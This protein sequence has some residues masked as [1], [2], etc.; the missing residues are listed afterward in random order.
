M[1]LCLTTNTA[2]SVFLLFTHHISVQ[3]PDYYDII[4]KPIA[5]NT[6][7]EKVNNCEY[8]TAGEPRVD[9]CGQ[10]MRVSVQNVTLISLPLVS[11]GEYISDVELMFSNCL[12]YNPRHTNEAKAGHRL[13]RFFHAELS[14]LGLL[15]HVSALPTKRSRH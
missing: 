5:L 4:K 6:I 14:R 1:S 15:E 3:V 7:R 11:A 12:Q 9:H 10:N 2:C 13:Q 8:Q